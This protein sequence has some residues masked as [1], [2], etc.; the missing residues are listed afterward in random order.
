MNTGS[1]CGL[2]VQMELVMLFLK[3]R[4]FIA[5]LGYKFWETAFYR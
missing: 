3:A 1:C 5:R 4:D 2:C